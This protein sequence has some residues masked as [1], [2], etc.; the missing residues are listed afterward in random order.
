MTDRSLTDSLLSELARGNA[1]VLARGRELATLLTARQLEW[2]P[3]GGGWTAGQV[4]E[5]L[6]LSGSLYVDRMDAIIE[7]AR[8]SGKT[9]NRKWRPTLMGGMII[10]GVRPQSARR[11][12]TQ[13]VFQPG[14]A[15]RRDAVREFVK[16]HERLDEL[17]AR[18]DGLDLRGVKLSSPAS[19]LIRM[20]LGDAFAI[21]VFHAQRH[22]LQ[23]GRI[24]NS[25]GFPR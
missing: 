19:S 22:L 23:V 6:L 5:H 16:L 13:T 7:A 3:Q 10:R 8:T 20:N 24:I 2:Q 25:P 15:A 21:L 12:R 4:I 18:A 1:E 14:P 11:F 9:G 17:L